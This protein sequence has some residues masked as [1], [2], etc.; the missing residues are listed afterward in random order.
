MGSK[1]P[2]MN[3]AMVPE[4]SAGFSV[5]LQKF[6]TW[7]LGF[8]RLS[9][10]FDD[11]VPRMLLLGFVTRRL[12]LK[13]L[14]PGFDDAVPRMLL[15]GF[16]TRKDC[17]E[18]GEEDGEG[19]GDWTEAW[20]VDSKREERVTMVIRRFL[21]NAIV[22]E[23]LLFISL[24]KNFFVMKNRDNGKPCYEMRVEAWGFIVE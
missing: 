19:E 4:Q 20:A 17:A 11:A 10:A 14:S 1:G 2:S 24:E 18:D 23:L 5:P 7:R 6:M 16:A 21:L 12:D 9:P 3:G 8:K 13:R 15:L 22:S